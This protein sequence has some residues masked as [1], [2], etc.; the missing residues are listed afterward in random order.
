[1]G[2]LVTSA[3]PAGDG[4]WTT[5]AGLVA[6]NYFLLTENWWG[7]IDDLG[8]PVASTLVDPLGVF[9]TDNLPVGSYFLTTDNQLTKISEPVPLRSVPAPVRSRVIGRLEW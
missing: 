2:A 8:D 7:F 5:D 6:G 3:D 1:M 9:S 4:S